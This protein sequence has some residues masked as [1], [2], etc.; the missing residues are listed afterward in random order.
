M[1]DRQKA[2]SNI[3]RDKHFSEFDR[4]VYRAILKVSKGKVLTATGSS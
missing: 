1:R 3:L 2:L 4:D